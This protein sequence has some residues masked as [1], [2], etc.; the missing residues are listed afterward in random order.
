MKKLT[1]F[2]N[3]CIGFLG[4]LM[5]KNPGLFDGSPYIVRLEPKQDDSP[6]FPKS[7]RLFSFLT[8]Y[9]VHNKHSRDFPEMPNCSEKWPQLSRTVRPFDRWSWSIPWAR[10]F[11][12]LPLRSGTFL[13]VFI[14][15]CLYKRVLYKRWAFFE[16]FFVVSKSRPLETK[17]F[18]LGALAG[19][20]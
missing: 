13:Y 2:W 4:L 1:S 7:L 20:F 8:S 15:F 10:P 3:L 5:P 14:L 17:T 19:G 9:A 16:M 11:L 18:S 6:T 12:S